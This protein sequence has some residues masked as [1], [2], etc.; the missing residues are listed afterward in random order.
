VKCG[1]TIDAYARICP[2]CN[3]DQNEPVPAV[4]AAALEGELPEYEP[5]PDT[6]RRKMIFAIGG[7]VLGIILAFIIGMHVHGNKP[8]ATVPGKDLA[9]TNA[10]PAQRQHANVTL[11]PDNGPAPNI[12]QPITSAPATTTAQGLPNEY[13]RTDATAASSDQYAQMAQRAKAEKKK[14]S[15]LVNPLSITGAAYDVNPRPAA[16]AAIP[17]PMPSSMMSAE[18]ARTNPIPEYQPLPPIRVRSPQT[19]RI[20]LL[21]GA[22]GRVH[23]V[24]VRQGLGEN[25]GQLITAVQS[26]RFKPATLNGNAVA[27]PFSVELSFNGNE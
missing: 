11:V 17:S 15:V 14:M 22:D 2:Y 1:R 13:Q 5:P 9:T 20:E 24:S 18:S 26:W 4:K 6:R 16:R 8:P 19:A 12:E 25:T 10:T 3:W 27:A 7:G 23:D 21:I